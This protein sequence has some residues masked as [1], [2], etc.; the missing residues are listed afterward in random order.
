[1]QTEEKNYLTFEDL[2]VYR[3][4]R[5]FR[6]EMYAVARKLPAIEKFE[7]APQIRDAAR[8][9]T[10]NVAEGHGRYHF[11]DQIKF[12]LQARGSLQEL[13]DDL[14]LCE[15]ENYLP[16]Q[17][18]AKIRT[19]GVR[20]MKLLKGYI[21]FLRE[22]KVGEQLITRESAAPYHLDADDPFDDST[23]QPFNDLTKL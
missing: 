9:L 18:I 6:K 3:A 8:S 13:F 19:D 15:D 16:P 5:A 12:M 23:I 17:E 14:N 7:L 2:E 1:M 10:N 4:A 20:V 21:R 22:R 11:L